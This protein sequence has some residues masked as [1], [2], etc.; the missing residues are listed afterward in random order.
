MGRL[1]DL[2]NTIMKPFSV[3]TAY[4]TIEPGDNAGDPAKF[5]PLQVREGVPIHWVNT[6]RDTH[7]PWPLDDKDEFDETVQRG[8]DFYLS[9]P[10]PGDPPP[11]GTQPATSP[12]PSWTVKFRD[13]KNTLRYGCKLHDKE[14]GEIRKKI[15]S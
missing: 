9:D 11:P 8:G 2:W 10:V 6:T 13:Q 5:T 14:R 12:R 7:Q 3:G 4:V 1:S 15:D